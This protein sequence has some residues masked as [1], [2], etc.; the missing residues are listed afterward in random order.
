MYDDLSSLTAKLKMS[1]ISFLEMNEEEG[2]TMQAVTP[3]TTAIESNDEG[4]ENPANNVQ[5]I[6][7][8]V[9]TT[10]PV[11]RS[12][13]AMAGGIM[14]GVAAMTRSTEKEVYERNPVRLDMLFT[15]IG[16]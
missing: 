4:E 8:P 10:A 6:S 2:A 7:R 5:P 15:V 12:F 1:G 3:L 14:E 11:Q 13:S 9:P 16:K